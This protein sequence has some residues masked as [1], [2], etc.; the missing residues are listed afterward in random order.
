MLTYLGASGSSNTAFTNATNT[1]SASQN[2]N[3]V[4]TVTGA[5]NRVILNDTGSGVLHLAFQAN[6]VTKGYIGANASYSFYASNASGAYP[7]SSDQSGNFTAY[8]NITSSSDAR[9]KK[10]VATVTDAL[11]IVS[12]LRGVWYTR[13]DTG[14]DRVG[15]IAQEIDE[16]LPE[17]V[18][19][20]P[21]TGYL[22]VS[23]GD[24]VGVLIE[25]IKE[26]KAEVD[27]LKK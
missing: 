13:I 11:D 19:E 23:Y 22:S 20:N 2:I 16:V 10:D 17:V 26:L 25:A 3:G 18:Y 27:S 7:I 4:L 1:F 8:G 24:I 21:E 14:A 9:L 12:E 15:V 5:A 6:G